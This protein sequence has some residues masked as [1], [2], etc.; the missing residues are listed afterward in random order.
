VPYRVT[1]RVGPRV[2]R[3]AADSLEEALDR[4]E[5]RCRALAAGPRRREVRLRQ[6]TFSPVQQV[7]ARAEVSG[8]GRLR[9]AV[10]AGVDVRGDGSAEAWTGGVRRELVTQEPGESAYAAL[11]RTLGAAG[12]SGG[13]TSAEP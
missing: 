11:R 9:P 10:R 6:R 7:A 2:D 5:A 3:A 8:P 4:L 1:L 13:S 12:A